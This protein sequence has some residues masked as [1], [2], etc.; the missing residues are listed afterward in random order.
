MSARTSFQLCS[1]TS[2]EKGSCKLSEELILRDN[3]AF[4]PE[5]SINSV[6]LI[7]LYASTKFSKLNDMLYGHRVLGGKAIKKAGNN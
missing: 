3:I 5:F 6:T 4:I 1:L 7:F 2:P